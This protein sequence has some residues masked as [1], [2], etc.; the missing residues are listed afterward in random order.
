MPASL[1]LIAVIFLV[2]FVIYLPLALRMTTNERDN[3]FIRVACRMP[4]RSSSDEVSLH[5]Q[6]Y[7]LG[8]SSMSNSLQAT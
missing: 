7:G 6:T 5:I 2:I 1:M 3:E 8:L 4:C